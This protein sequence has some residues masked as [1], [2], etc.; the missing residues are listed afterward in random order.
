MTRLFQK[1]RRDVRGAVT[2]FVTLL[3][4]PALLITGTGVDIARI[5]AARSVIHDAN[6]LA[7]NSALASYN[8][9]LHDLYGLFGMMTEEDGFKSSLQDYVNYSIFP[10]DGR[11]ELGTFQLFYGSAPKS[12]DFNPAT[13]KHL[14]NAPVL[15]RQIEDYSKFRAP[16][17]IVREILQRLD[18][19][20]EVQE[21]FPLYFVYIPL[22]V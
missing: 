9:L 18:T 19:F 1:V 12:V 8:A 5:Y 11:K 22:K 16:V 10:K 7:A 13:N 6:Q 2:V 21:D 3:L 4:I 14:A 17:I 20:Q 15:R